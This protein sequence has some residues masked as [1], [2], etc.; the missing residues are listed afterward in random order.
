M[1]LMGAESTT[2][3]DADQLLGLAAAIARDPEKKLKLL[4]TLLGEASCRQVGIYRIPPGFKLSVV[5]P[6]FNELQ[7]IR[8]IVRRVQEVPI[9]KELIL[10]DDFSTD[11][12]R[13]LLKEMESVD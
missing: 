3:T 5:I 9:P 6:V 7:W 4:H 2:G 10:V 11:G 8:E 12:T 1:I 13:A